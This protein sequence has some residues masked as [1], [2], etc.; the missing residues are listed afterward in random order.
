MTN[1]DETLFLVIFLKFCVCMVLGKDFCT[2]SQ[3][4]WVQV[5]VLLA[6]CL[7]EFPSLSTNLEISVKLCLRLYPDLMAL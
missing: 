1:E 5:L 7:A 2:G 4:S 6:T 3:E